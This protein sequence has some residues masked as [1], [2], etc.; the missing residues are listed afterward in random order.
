MEKGP[1]TVLL[2]S[3]GRETVTRP[4]H[5]PETL[6]QIGQCIHIKRASVL[7]SHALSH[8]MSRVDETSFTQCRHILNNFLYALTTRRRRYSRFSLA[9]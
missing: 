9:G 2:I 4:V 8:A 7:P 6:L 3:V 5:C 1:D